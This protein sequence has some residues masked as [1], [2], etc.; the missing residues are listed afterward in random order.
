MKIL[1]IL[2]KLI[3]IQIILV[4]MCSNINIV[5][6]RDNNE[7]N[8]KIVNSWEKLKEEIES[9][10]N[11]TKKIVIETNKSENWEADSTITI[12]EN[13]KIL[14]ITTNNVVIQRKQ[15]F[16]ESLL[17]N[18]GILILGNDEMEGNITFDGNKEKVTSNKPLINS[19][20]G[21]LIINNNINI[22]NNHSTENGGGVSL[23]NTTANIMRRNNTKQCF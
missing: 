12:K 18:K 13:Q 20:K 9:T 8:I 17:E 15:E 22:Q 19:E 1:Q 21:E 5:Y 7:G 16:K 10:N 6:S 11:T 14:I 3:Y 4:L 23:T 2:K